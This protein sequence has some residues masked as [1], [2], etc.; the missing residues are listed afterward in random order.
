[1]IL[2]GLTALAEYGIAAHL[3]LSSR[4]SNIFILSAVGIFA[5]YVLVVSFW[6][7]TFR[8]AVIDYLG[9]VIFLSIALLRLYSRIRIRATLIGISGL[10]LTVVAS[11]VQQAHISVDPHYFNHNALYHLLEAIALFLIYRA[12]R[13]LLQIS[14]PLENR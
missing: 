3:M 6:D 11:A 2:L 12:G 13:S 9:G 8:I 10:L 4:S 7:A 14:L 1:M 5:L